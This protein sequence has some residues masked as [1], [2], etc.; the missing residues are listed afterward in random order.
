M[1]LVPCTVRGNAG[2]CVCV[3]V[4]VCWGVDLVVLDWDVGG[5]G[6]EP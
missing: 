4:C 1:D 2:V 5:S 3:C 6:L